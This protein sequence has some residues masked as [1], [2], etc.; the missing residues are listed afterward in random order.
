MATLTVKLLATRE[1][2]FH[3]VFSNAYIDFSNF[4]Q[5]HQRSLSVGMHANYVFQSALS[6]LVHKALLAYH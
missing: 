5:M 3:V 6:A 4:L 1:K 2:T